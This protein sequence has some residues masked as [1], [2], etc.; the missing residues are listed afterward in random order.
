MPMKNKTVVDFPNIFEGTIMLRLYK[1]S[2]PNIIV[3]SLSITIINIKL[4]INPLMYKE[5]K[6]ANK[7][8]LSANG[9]A[10]VPNLVILLY[11]R[12]ICPSNISVIPEVI[13]IIIDITKLCGELL[14]NTNINNGIKHR[15]MVVNI[16]G[17]FNNLHPLT[18]TIIPV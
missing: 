11:L 10:T 7:V 6:T 18:F 16:L 13:N 14:K 17:I 8:S 3:T 2:P 4:G 5:N 12:A 1:N 9:S 15:R